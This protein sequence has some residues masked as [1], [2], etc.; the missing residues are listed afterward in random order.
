MKS[1]NEKRKNSISQVI[2]EGIYDG[3]L[4]IKVKEG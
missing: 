3:F 2:R 4:L 1:F